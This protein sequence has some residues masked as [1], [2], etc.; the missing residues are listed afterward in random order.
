MKHTGKND[1]RLTVTSG[2]EFRVDDLIIVHPF[3]H[4]LIIGVVL[5]GFRGVARQRDLFANGRRDFDY[6]R[7]LCK[8][9]QTSKLVCDTILV[10]PA[11]ESYNMSGSAF[12]V[13]NSV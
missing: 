8:F 4:E 13:R 11:N 9:M 3:Q 2:T 7:H 10:H 1:G 6:V 5:Y 12:Y